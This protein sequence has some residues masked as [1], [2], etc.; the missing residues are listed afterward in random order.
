MMKAIVKTVIGW[1]LI[2]IVFGLIS[3]TSGI[4]VALSD[5]SVGFKEGFLIPIT[6][7][8]IVFFWS[9]ICTAGISLFVWV[10]GPVFAGYA[11]G[12]IIF[13]IFGWEP[14]K[15]KTIFIQSNQNPEPRSKLRVLTERL[16]Q[17]LHNDPVLNRNQSALFNYIK[18]AR[19]KGLTNEQIS[20]NLQHNGWPAD[21]V[22]WLLNFAG[23]GS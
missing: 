10:I 2:L 1:I 13:D 17:E 7:V 12:H 23:Q 16:N 21:S 19:E 15:P 22:N 18:K 9:V 6:A 5:P 8:W 4:I 14:K 20:L 3:I 11:L